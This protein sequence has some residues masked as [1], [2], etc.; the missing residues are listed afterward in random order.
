MT[1]EKK[2]P[3]PYNPY[4]VESEKVYGAHTDYRVCS[5][6][7]LLDYFAGQALNGDLSCSQEGSGGTYEDYAKFAYNMAEAMLRERERRMNA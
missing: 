1:C 6:I 7:T 5:E 2:E 4:I 3:M